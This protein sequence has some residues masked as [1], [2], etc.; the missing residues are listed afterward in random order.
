M[1]PSILGISSSPHKGGKVDTVVREILNASGLPSEMVR[2]HEI[3][4]GPCIACNGCRSE[5]VCVLNDDWGE[6]QRKIVEAR[7]LVL[8]GWVF[9]G[10]IDSAC[11]AM[12]ERFWSFRHHHQLTRGK[13]GAVVM[14]GGNTV[15]AGGLADALTQFM[16]NNGIMPL[17]SVTAAGSNPCLGC[18]DALEG[19]EF[20]AVVA[21][22]GL[23]ERTGIGMYN[24]IEH[25]LKVLKEARI[26]GQRLGHKINC[27]TEKGL[28]AQAV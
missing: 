12:M 1:K 21:Q 17:G 2:L 9:S 28:Y 6:L 25:Q 11:K 23:L 26:L 5:N 7:A 13:V 16:R 20:S 15:M 27:L 14:V 18:E 4:V 10:M 22:Y 8:G 24:P 19:C 3:D